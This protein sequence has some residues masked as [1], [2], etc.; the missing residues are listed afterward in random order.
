MTETQ[1]HDWAVRY[2]DNHRNNVTARLVSH[3]ACVI[4]DWSTHSRIAY[5]HTWLECLASFDAGR[6]ALQSTTTEDK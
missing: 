4:F 2:A 1:A 6:D 5:G 3:D